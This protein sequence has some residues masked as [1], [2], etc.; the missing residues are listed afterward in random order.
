[1]GRRRDGNYTL[2]KD[3]SIE[4]SVGNEK[5]GYTGPDP[6]KRMMSLRSPVMSTK[7]KSS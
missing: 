3:D 5:N 2:Q 7:K 1:M 4:N 6:S